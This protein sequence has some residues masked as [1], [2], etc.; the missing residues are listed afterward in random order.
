M[1]TEYTKDKLAA[2]PLP[3]SWLS[4]GCGI[5]VKTQDTLWK[6]QVC[7][8]DAADGDPEYALEG[9]YCNW[10]Q[11]I[12]KCKLIPRW[13]AD[14]NTAEMSYW[15]QL[16]AAN[17]EDIV[18]VTV[19]GYTASLRVNHAQF[20]STLMLKS[21]IAPNNL[22]EVLRMS[23]TDHLIWLASYKE[24]HD[25]L[26]EQNTYNKINQFKMQ[27]YA[28]MGCAIVSCMTVFAIKPNENGKLYHA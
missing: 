7:K 25:A 17:P 16:S 19:G 23:N 20:V 3:P 26:I 4:E 14:P 1:D 21:K 11:C 22:C 12:L 10:Q 8:V 13:P 18:D 28:V 5:T 27:R 15:L 24:E 2:N 6:L 9:L